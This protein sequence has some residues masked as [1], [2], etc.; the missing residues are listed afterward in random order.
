[1]DKF[2]QGNP[3]FLLGELKEA[4]VTLDNQIY[5]SAKARKMTMMTD[6]SAEPDKEEGVKFAINWQKSTWD[7]KQDHQSTQTIFKKYFYWWIG[8]II[9]FD[10][11]RVHPL[12]SVYLRNREI[13]GYWYLMQNEK[14]SRNVKSLEAL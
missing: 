9:L 13:L 6:E 10:L 4:Y 2:T 14:I 7:S 1:M 8:I 12:T 11:N 5:D 3:K